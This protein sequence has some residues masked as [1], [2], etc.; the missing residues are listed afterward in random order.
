MANVSETINLSDGSSIA[1][2]RLPEVDDATW[3]EVRTYLEG[4]PEMAKNL[5]KFAKNPDAMRGWLQT[6]AIA[7][8]YS[9]ALQQEESNSALESKL[10]SLEHDPEL[11]PIFKDIRENGLAAAMKHTGDEDL[12]LKISQKMGG[13]PSELQPKLQKIQESSLNFHE[14]AKNGDLKAVQDY[15]EKKQALDVQ[16]HKGITPL[17][18][19]VGANRIA[20]VKLLLDKRANPFS[21]DSAGNS[22]LHYSAGYGRKELLEYLLKLGVNVNQPNSQGQTPLSVAQ[23]NRHEG[24]VSLLKAH[25][26][27]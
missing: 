7:E 16:D 23:L 4:N 10:K 25:G 19:A 20:V 22:G 3:S 18:Y 24:V 27:Q 8:H 2:T 13:L 6:Q 9:S 12:M 11:A 21:V 17:G 14:A 15:I 26:A 5:Q 1:I